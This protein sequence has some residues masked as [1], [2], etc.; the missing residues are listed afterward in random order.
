MG[1]DRME[2]KMNARYSMGQSKPSP[3]LVTLVYLVLVMGV[4]FLVNALVANPLNDAMEYLS[5]GY[6]WDE[7]WEYAFARDLSVTS[8][9]G[10]AALSLSLYQLFMS[11]GYTSYALRLARN[12]QPGFA[13]LFDGFAK[14][15][16]VLWL[17]ILTQVFTF[18][19]TLLYMLPLIA[20]YIVAGVGSGD[21]ELIFG[22][23][24]PLSLVVVIMNLVVSLRYRLARYF[25]IDDPDCTAYQALKRSRA[26]MK[27]WKMELF[28]LELSFLPWLLL[29]MFTMGI[30]FIWVT[31]YA[32]TTVA[33]FYDFVTARTALAGSG[34]YM[35][36][37]YDRDSDSGPNP[38]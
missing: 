22:L 33:N 19:W 30:L 10:V 4:T 17:S 38:F 26:A 11:F 3:M 31:P 29:A 27:G 34:G 35:G 15:L 25:V 21:V 28:L 20:V 13:R 14:F 7:V 23:T 8:T 16:R 36:Q 5:W 12:E 37:I 6:A 24:G 1:F 32:A 2:A 18:L 9:Y